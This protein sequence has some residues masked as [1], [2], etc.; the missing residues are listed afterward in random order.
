MPEFA[1]VKGYEGL[2]RVSSDGY[3]WSVRQSKR[4]SPSRG[5]HGHLRVILYKTGCPPKTMTVHK[6]VKNSFHGPTPDGLFV[7]HNNGDPT[8][9]RLFNLRF[10]TPSA[11]MYD[12]Q[13]HGTDHLR[14]RTH[15]PRGH[16]LA[17]PNLKTAKIE[18]GWRGCK[19]CHQASSD[20]FNGSELSFE[21]LANM[22]YFMVMT[23][24]TFKHGKRREGEIDMYKTS[25]E[26]KAGH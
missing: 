25:L 8:D 20:R 11:N 16:E 10:D 18:L 12:K 9:N 13:K 14:N 26:W 17:E 6:L 7:C 24:R 19:A 1:D 5:K 3:V 4:M 23:G 15:C 2:Y 21:E 22:R